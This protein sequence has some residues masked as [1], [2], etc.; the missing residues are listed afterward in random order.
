MSCSYNDNNLYNHLLRETQY[1]TL[2]CK[3]SHYCIHK[4]ELIEDG[5]SFCYNTLLYL[6]YR[7]RY[8]Y[9]SY[10]IKDGENESLQ[11][12]KVGGVL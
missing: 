9:H 5:F 7:S 10:S 11:K 1:Y 2:M 6:Y 4:I 12:V 8:T 3:V